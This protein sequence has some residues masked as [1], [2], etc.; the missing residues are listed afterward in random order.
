MDTAIFL[1]LRH[2]GKGIPYGRSDQRSDGSKNHGFR[3]LREHPDEIANIPEAQDITALKN[4]LTVLNDADCP[5]FTVGCE[6]AFNK[7]DSGHW[8]RGYFE[9]AFNYRELV[10]DPQFY[11][12]LFFYFSQWH[13]RQ[14]FKVPVRYEFE[15]QEAHFSK[16]NVD[17]FTLTV[18]ITT[19]SLPSRELAQNA[20]ESAVNTV[21]K[22][23]KEDVNIISGGPYTHI[24]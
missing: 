10:A 16:T 2:G 3:S 7:N 1:S 20:W 4:A 24:Y 5:F 6:K 12:K 9:F 14:K 17:G 8:L 18:W 22:F 11:F 21:V 15:L 23:L 13:W 19:A